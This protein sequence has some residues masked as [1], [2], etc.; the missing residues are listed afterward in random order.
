MK[1]FALLTSFIIGVGILITFS[2]SLAGEK[3]VVRAG[4][5]GNPH[6]APLFVAEDKGLFKNHGLK[7][8]LKKFG[9]SSEIGYALLTKKIELGFLELPRASKL[10]KEHQQAVFFIRFFLIPIRG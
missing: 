5:T 7:M 10:L 1:K 6:L 8:V 4:H 9:S 3:G 2:L